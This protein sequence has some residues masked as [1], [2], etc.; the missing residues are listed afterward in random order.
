[1]AHLRWHTSDR[2][3]NRGCMSVRACARIHVSMCACTRMRVRLRVHVRV[4]VHLH[5]HI[6]LRQT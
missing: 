2:L 1:M 5:V 4:R 6:D 3:S